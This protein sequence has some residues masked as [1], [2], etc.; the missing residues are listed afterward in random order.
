MKTK[1]SIL[2]FIVITTNAWSQ[3][4]H[5]TNIKDK[6]YMGGNVGLSGN[7]NNYLSFRISPLLGIKLTPKFY[8]GVGF[9]Y[10]YTSDKR[11]NRKISANDYGARIFGQYNIIPQLFAHAEYAGYS[12]DS[13]YLNIKDNRVFVPYLLLGGGYRKQISTRSFFSIRVLFDVLQDEYSPY[14]PGQPYISVGF[15]IGL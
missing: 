4:D 13:Y 8:T 15:G 14:E 7:F 9:E 5:S 3:E 2:L 11:Y 6:L 10:I 12:Y 1:L